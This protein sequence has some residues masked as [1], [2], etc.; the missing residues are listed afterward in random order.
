[1]AITF[2]GQATDQGVDAVATSQN[3]PAPSGVGAGDFMLA[4]I[5]G[6]NATAPPAQTGWN[7][8]L[9]VGSTAQYTGLYWRIRETSDPASWTFTGL[10]SARVSSQTAAWRG[11]DPGN[12]LDGIAASGTAGTTA[13]AFPAVTPNSSGAWIVG[14]ITV[15]QASTTSYT[16]SATN[17][18]ATR[19]TVIGPNAGATVDPGGAILDEVWTSGAFTF[20]ATSTSATTRTRG[21]RFVLRPAPP[22]PPALVMPPR[23]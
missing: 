18:D 7:S 8:I 14:V 6:N 22:I 12:P 23:N 13:I 20:T 9:L 21:S 15:M 11:V 1:M 5:H 17:A 16:L 19:S 4:A 10:A 2:V 3:I